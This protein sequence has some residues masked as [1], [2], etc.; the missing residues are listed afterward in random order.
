METEDV[1]QFRPRSSRSGQMVILPELDVFIHL[2]ILLRMI[3]EERMEK[4]R[5]EGGREGGR[6][7]AWIGK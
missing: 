4:V 7:M 2:L 6:K 3:D 1:S 5:R